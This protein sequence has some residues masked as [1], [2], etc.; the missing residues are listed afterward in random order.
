M[1]RSIIRI[2]ALAI[3]SA[4][5]AGCFPDDYLD[6]RIDI[7]N[8]KPQPKPEPEPEP[9]PEPDPTPG[10][11]DGLSYDNLAAY[12]GLKNYVNRQISPDFKLGAGVTVSEFLNDLCLLDIPGHKAG[13][14]GAACL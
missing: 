11:D 4:S 3:L 13:D 9:E 10:V 2:L 1:N 6:D 14:A 7:E 12:D 8:I 5:L